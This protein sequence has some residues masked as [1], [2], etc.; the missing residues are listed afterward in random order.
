MTKKGVFRK[1]HLHKV[2]RKVEGKVVVVVYCLRDALIF[3]VCIDRA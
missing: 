2:L 3:T 1:L